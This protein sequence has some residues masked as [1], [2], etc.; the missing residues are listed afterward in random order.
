MKYRADIDG[1]RAVAV[2]TVIFFH[3]GFDWFSGGF[4]G[5]DVFFVIS[6]FLITSI[7]IDDLEANR[8]SLLKF[9]ERRVRRILPA[10]FFITVVCLPFAFIW[11]LPSQL[12]EFSQSLVA[13]SWFASNIYFSIKSGYFDSDT[14]EKPLLHT[15]SLAVEEQYYIIFPI[16]LLFLW[17]LGK[18]RPLTALS[19][20][21][22]ASLLFSEWGWRNASDH[23]FYLLPSR[24][25]ELLAGSIVALTSRK[26]HVK[27]NSFMVF[28]G[29]VC[30]V[31]A[32]C[33]FDNMT[34][35]P[36]L[37]TLLPVGGAVL[38]ILFGDDHG[39]A[40]R[41][42]SYRPLVGLGLVSYSA[43]LWHQPLFAFARIRLAMP[44]SAELMILLSCLA[45]LLAYLSWRYVEKPF[46]GK[47]ALIKSR[48]ILFAS[49]LAVM[50]G[51]TA[52]G[53]F[54]H[55]SNGFESYRVRSF[56][57]D[58]N[59]LVFHQYI[60]DRYHDCEPQ[61][62]ANRSLDWA[63]FL[64]CKQSKLGASDW[65]LLG[66]S[67]AEHLFLGLVDAV[68]SKNIVFYIRNGKPYPSNPAFADI[69]EYLQSGI[70]PQKVFLTM[71]YL[72]RVKQKNDLSAGFGAAIKALKESGHQVVL[73]G[74]IPSYSTHPERCVYESDQEAVTPV[75]S[76]TKAKARLQFS[77]YKEVLLKLSKDYSVDYF[78][79]LEPLCDDERCS[80]VSNSEIFYRDEHHLNVIGSVL[81]GN[82]LAKKIGSD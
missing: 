43:Y 38:I 52:L 12:K 49:A 50:C 14:E 45:F 53:L 60:D 51:F 56:E 25:W 17:R 82:Y 79:I 68:P 37:Y 44:P 22:L 81:V 67:H 6:G 33:V 76:M 18:N 74:D 54:G 10:L 9:Y 21:A 73:L 7:L 55:W 42:L 31:I 41:I 15:W 20:L 78:S 35:F 34:P 75:C 5:V 69:Y 64:R 26:V 8:F 46:R 29:L 59:H 2:V 40:S 11:L 65:V 70:K 28:G 62:I 80:M 57:G 58:L 16:L 19:L 23:N 72:N 32:V 24:A 4:I 48:I 36:S 27:P 13:V 63:G 1:L 30:I 66:D 77:N 3:A 61:S 39:W 47:S 71:Y